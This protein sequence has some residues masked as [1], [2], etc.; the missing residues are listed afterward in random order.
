MAIGKDAK[1]SFSRTTLA[2]VARESGFSPST[3]SIVL[4]EAPI[5]KYVAAKTKEHIREVAKRLDYRPDAFGRSLRKRRSHTI[6]VMIFDISDPFCTLI[7]QGIEKNLHPT[8]FLPFIVDAHNQRKQF[9]RY[10]AMLLEYRVE[11]LIV[12]ANWL[13][14]D[15]EMLSELER[16][17][18]PTVLVGSEMRSGPLGSV[19]VNNEQGGYLALQHVYSLGHRK[20][21]FIRGPRPLWD[22]SRRW[23]GVLRYAAE[24][25][26]K[27][28]KKWVVE[29]TGSSESNSSF[30]EGRSLTRE[31]LEQDPG[32][33]ALLAFDDLTAFGAVR[34]LR[35]FG[36][37]VPKDCS[38]LGFDDVPYAA[39]FNPS[40]S[41]VRQP[42]E[43]MGS[44][45]VERILN[46]I[47]QGAE[48]A[49]GK[50]R[51]DL[52]PPEIVQRE[53]TAAISVQGKVS[54]KRLGKNSALDSMPVNA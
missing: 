12:V 14:I 35:D 23:A 53:S 21:A 20:I 17:R 9:E 38:V 41:T 1:N 39:L 40:L 43:R 52:L 49:Q 48:M 51:V 25:G 46:E 22:S 18:V 26:L 19:L 45:A 36:R 2:D 28:P 32:F 8:E 42:M 54:A 7:L 27:M 44:I 3:I 30:D 24:V 13:F 29:L 37:S 6:G 34:A 47:Q 16:H 31:M 5:S 4:N 11:G 33:T 15:I 10:L 50:G